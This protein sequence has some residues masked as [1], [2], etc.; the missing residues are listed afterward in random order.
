MSGLSNLHSEA[1]QSLG[2]RDLTGFSNAV[3]KMGQLATGNADLRFKTTALTKMLDAAAKGDMGY[4]TKGFMDVF[5]NHINNGTKPDGTPYTF[6][7]VLNTGVNAIGLKLDS[8]SVYALNDSFF[9]KYAE[10][11]LKTDTGI[12]I[13]PS[14]IKKIESGYLLPTKEQMMAEYKNMLLR[15]ERGKSYLFNNGI[16]PDNPNAQDLNKFIEDAVN[17]IYESMMSLYGPTVAYEGSPMKDVQVKG[18]G[19]QARVTSIPEDMEVGPDGNLRPK[20][21]TKDGGG[22]QTAA[23]KLQEARE[24]S[25]R[26]KFGEEAVKDPDI[27]SVVLGVDKHE[28]Y[29]AQVEKIA[30]EK[31]YKRKL[32]PGQVAE[33]GGAGLVPG[34][35]DLPNTLEGIKNKFS[36]NID[37][38]TTKVIDKNGV[39]YLITNDDNVKTP[40]KQYSKA[41][42]MKDDLWDEDVMGFGD[43]VQ[44]VIPGLT[45]EEWDVPKLDNNSTV[46]NLGP[47]P[48]GAETTSVSAPIEGLLVAKDKLEGDSEFATLNEGG[49]NPDFPRQTDFTNPVSARLVRLAD[50]IVRYYDMQVSDTSDSKHMSRAQSVYR[51]SFDLQ[52]ENEKGRGTKVLPKD[53]TIT[54]LPEVMEAFGRNGL[55]A[56]YELGSQEKVNELFAKYKELTGKDFPYKDFVIAVPHATGNHFSIY[57]DDCTPWG[58]KGEKTGG[59][60]EA[61]PPPNAADLKKTLLTNPLISSQY[62]NGK[63]SDE[64]MDYLT[65]FLGSEDIQDGYLMDVRIPSDRKAYNE[66]IKENSNIKKEFTDNEIMYTIHFLGTGGAKSFFR[67]NKKKLPEDSN[68]MYVFSNNKEI[69]NKSLKRAYPIISSGDYVE[70]LGE[71]EAKTYTTVN[72]S[73]PNSSAIGKYQITAVTDLPKIRD[74]IDQYYEE[75]PE[76]FTGETRGGEE[77]GG[78]QTQ[79][80][81]FFDNF[82]SKNPELFG[83]Q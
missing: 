5:F 81:V 33:D 22:K 55:R 49:T 48:K 16:N 69:K 51:T 37:P 60:A 35:T 9:K 56:E 40:L 67:K 53:E 71:V 70:K 83:G 26:A 1:A 42:Q 50:P 27:T 74:Y 15:D 31:G 59:I 62:K 11:P 6:D 28:D 46:F 8:K 73:D 34:T 25:I 43:S 19:E 54:K 66:I 52:F 61:A 18:F 29:L 32:L 72:K 41:L 80:G 10:K 64:D 45:L 76:A 24:A 4:N 63:L 7:E 12:E 38:N 13:L 17:P 30:K 44:D 65:R 68:Q 36:L 82:K 78:T 23:D 75:N 47:S 2:R 57:C 21:K 77:E 58:A 14:G 3:A 39:R 20:T 79:P